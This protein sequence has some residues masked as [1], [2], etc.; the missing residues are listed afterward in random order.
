MG[1]LYRK[2][3]VTTATMVAGGLAL[4]G[5]PLISA[6][7][8]S[9]DEIF[10]EAF[11]LPN[12]VGLFVLLFLALAAILTAFYTY[13]MLW[14]TFFGSPRTEAAVNAAHYEPARGDGPAERYISVTLTAPL[15][16]LSVF[17]ILAGFVGVHPDF[18][19]VGPLLNALG[20]KKPFISFVNNTLPH[21]PHSPDFSIVP[22]LVSL[23][24]FTIGV[25]VAYLLYTRRPVV[26]GQPDPVEG[27]VGRDVYRT[28]SAKYFIDEFYTRYLVRPFA[29]FADRVVNQI[30]DRG[31]IDGILHFVARTAERIGDVFKD[32][33]RVVIDGVGDGIPEA[34]GDL[35]RGIR[36]LQT[37]RVQQYLLYAL[38]ATLVVGINL[39]ILAASPQPG[40]IAALGI[41][42]GIIAVAVLFIFTPSTPAKPGQDGGVNVGEPAGSSDTSGD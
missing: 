4:M 28:L 2:M 23:L 20:I 33:N 25:V 1:G 32:F 27:Y 10:L 40:V 17:A 11:V 16:V 38:I 34:I 14:M 35:A 6:G 3:P 19:L 37:G 12:P 41:V 15:I 36:P 18:P 31:I 13:R 9:K 21:H 30:I 39:A 29:W 8:W 26:A 7:F 24:V 22:L 5:F 42:Q